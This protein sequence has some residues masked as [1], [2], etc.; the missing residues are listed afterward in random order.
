MTYFKSPFEIDTVPVS[1]RAFNYGDGCFTTILF[2]NGHLQLLDH[3]LNRLKHDTEKLSIDFTKFTQLEDYLKSASFFQAL[4]SKHTAAVKI[5]ISRGVGGRGYTPPAKE[6]AS[7]LCAITIHDYEYKGASKSADLTISSFTL[8]KQSALAGLKHANR[9]EQILA[10]QA[11]TLVNERRQRPFD[12]ALLLD[13]D[14]HII[15]ATAANVF[16]LINNVWCT[17]DLS[18]SGVSGVMRGFI[19]KVSAEMGVKTSI[20]N[21]TYSN[22][23]QAK[24]AFTCNA[25]SGITPIKTLSSNEGKIEYDSQASTDLDTVILTALMDTSYCLN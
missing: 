13:C 10:K 21:L 6:V 24:S 12:D 4:K 11:L 5:F 3:H 23:R 15:E 17:P 20:T 25:L 8:S 22:I 7:A 16:F 19:L 18:A 2:L 14:Q 1:D 9:L